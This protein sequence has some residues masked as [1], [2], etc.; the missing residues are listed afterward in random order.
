ML[1]PIIAASLSAAVA[2][3]NRQSALSSQLQE[4]GTS[5]KKLP[6]WRYLM[7][8]SLLKAER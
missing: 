4:E 2:F 6:A 5:L 8:S 7:R 1:T 3:G